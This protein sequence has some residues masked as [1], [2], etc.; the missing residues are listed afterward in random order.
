MKNSLILLIASLLF[1]C[2]YNDLSNATIKSG[3]YKGT[4]FRASKNTDEPNYEVANVTITFTTNQFSG[5]S[6]K[7]H[8]PAICNGA[9]KITG[10]EIDFTNACFFTADFDW[11]FILSGTYEI[12]SNGTLL[13]LQ[14]TSGSDTDYYY[15]T[16]Q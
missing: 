8:Y 13:Q 10:H 11:S 12:K 5:V 7:I 1:G 2:Q 14:R 3:A 4:F 15:L 9:Y 6:D 16:L